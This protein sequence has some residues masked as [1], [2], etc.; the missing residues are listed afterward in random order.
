MNNIQEESECY[1]NTMYCLMSRFWF[2]RPKHFFT[3]FVKQ[4]YEDG[5][6]LRNRKEKEN[7]FASR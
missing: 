7:E 6:N 1:A 2:L 5:Y 4:A 3:F